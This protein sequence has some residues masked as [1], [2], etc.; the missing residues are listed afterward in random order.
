M[1]RERHRTSVFQLTRA[2]KQPLSA[3]ICGFPHIITLPPPIIQGQSNSSSGRPYSIHSWLRQRVR[4]VRWFKWVRQQA[5]PQRRR[6]FAHGK[7]TAEPRSQ[8]W[9][10]GHSSVAGKEQQQQRQQARQRRKARRWVAIAVRWVPSGSL[11]QVQCAGVDAGASQKQLT[12]Q[13]RLAARFSPRRLRKWELRKLS[14]CAESAGEREREIELL[15]A[16]SP[17]QVAAV[18][19]AAVATGRASSNRP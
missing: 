8:R 2:L 19:G 5:P 17:N 10:R 7:P 1:N 18:E 13:R 6:D 3:L 9:Q 4:L 12:G 14:F 11:N 16:Q 15:G